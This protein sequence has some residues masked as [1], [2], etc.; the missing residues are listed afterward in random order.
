MPPSFLNPTS[1]TNWTKRA[2]YLLILA[3]VTSVIV[4]MIVFDFI[5]D[6]MNGRTVSQNTTQ[7]IDAWERLNSLFFFIAYFASA[8]LV[9]K[10]IYRANYNARQLGAGN[11]QFSSG[12]SIGWYFIPFANLWKPYQAMKEI[13]K[14]SANPS[15]WTNE[16]TPALL[17]WWWFL[18]IVT[19]IFGNIQFRMSHKEQQSLDYLSGLAILDI[20]SSLLTIILTMVLLSIIDKIHTMQLQHANQHTNTNRSS[21]PTAQF[22]SPTRLQLNCQQ[23]R[24]KIPVHAGTIVY[25]H[26]VYQHPILPQDVLGQIENHPKQTGAFILRNKSNDVWSYE[27]DGQSYRIEPTQARALTVGGKLKI[28]TAEIEVVSG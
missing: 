16:K 24:I 25:Q 22:Q 19:S 27:A 28:G 6:L 26:Q 20:F 14:T 2:L 4:D 17:G 8:I 13:W 1:L 15:S 7:Q 12:W 3:S 21:P 23:G 9:L 11:M 18:W 5:N 10:W